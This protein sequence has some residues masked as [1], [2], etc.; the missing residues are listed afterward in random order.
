MRINNY[1]RIN[2]P[3]MQEDKENGYLCSMC[4]QY[5]SKSESTS[6][7]GYNLVCLHCL[8]KMQYL[9]DDMNIMSKVQA[10]GRRKGR[11]ALEHE[12]L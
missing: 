8:Y 11:E 2:V 10:A 3:R 7:N 12:Q 5:T 9:T 4:G 1:D 6:Y